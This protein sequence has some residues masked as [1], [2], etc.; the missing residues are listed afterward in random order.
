MKI[1]ESEIAAECQRPCRP[2]RGVSRC[3]TT[4][5]K[6]FRAQITYGGRKY[7]LKDFATEEE[8]ARAYDEAAKKHHLKPKL[9]FLE[10][11]R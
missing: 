9:N 5:S 11:Y 1:T 3:G 8:A 4:P 7:N 6:P 10:D 2:Y